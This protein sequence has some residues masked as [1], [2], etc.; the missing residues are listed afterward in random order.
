MLNKVSFNKRINI[1]TEKKNST[2][3]KKTLD[4]INVLQFIFR[5][6]KNDKKKIYLLEM[7]KES[8]GRELWTMK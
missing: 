1:R 8:I 6:L 4:F 3:K 2:L 7:E 5:I